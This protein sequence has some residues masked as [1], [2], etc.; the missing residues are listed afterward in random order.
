ME[1]ERMVRLRNALAASGNK[2]LQDALV[3]AIGDIDNIPKELSSESTDNHS[4]GVSDY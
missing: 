3:A 1:E 4:E 2:K